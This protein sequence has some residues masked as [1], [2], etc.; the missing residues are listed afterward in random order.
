M[1]T[2]ILWALLGMAGYSFGTL[3][4]KLAERGGVA[5]THTVLAVSSMVVAFCALAIVALRGELSELF[6]LDPGTLLSP[7]SRSQL[8]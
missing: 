6:D 1:P 2:Y 7:A 4:V 3:F 8:P 5:S